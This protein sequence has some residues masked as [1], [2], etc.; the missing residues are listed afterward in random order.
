M[1]WKK[2]LT[3]C[4]KPIKLVYNKLFY[5]ELF[6]M[7]QSSIEQ[8]HNKQTKDDGRRA[9]G[10]RQCVIRSCLKNYFRLRKAFF[11]HV[12][13]KKGGIRRRGL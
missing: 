13:G 11:K 4:G 1:K 12:L 10:V 3:F 2:I 5:S 7:K 9:S 8:F 6:N